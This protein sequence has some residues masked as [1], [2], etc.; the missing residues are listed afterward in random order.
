MVSIYFV[1]D[2]SSNNWDVV[3]KLENIMV[4]IKSLHKINN[5]KE[6]VIKKWLELNKKCNNYESKLASLYYIS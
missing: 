6:T 2:C 3:A 5:M 1:R 4:N